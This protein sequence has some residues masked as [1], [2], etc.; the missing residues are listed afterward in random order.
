MSKKNSSKTIENETHDLP[1]CSAV[2]PPTA[3][4]RAPMR[5]LDSMKTRLVVKRVVCIPSQTLRT[6]IHSGLDCNTMLNGFILYI[7]T[8]TGSCL[9]FTQHKNRFLFLQ[10]PSFYNTTK[11]YIELKKTLQLKKIWNLDI[12]FK[13]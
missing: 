8:F 6:R 5:D 11:P 4:L 3:L 13:N 12:N 1:A 9:H 10:Y 2:L 7:F